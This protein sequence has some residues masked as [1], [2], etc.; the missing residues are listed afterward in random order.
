MKDPEKIRRSN[1]TKRARWPTKEEVLE[2]IDKW[3]I[4]RDI[5]KALDISNPLLRKIMKEYN[6]EYDFKRNLGSGNQW[7]KVNMETSY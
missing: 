4:C 2:A 1:E 6:I 3:K 5:S 7:R